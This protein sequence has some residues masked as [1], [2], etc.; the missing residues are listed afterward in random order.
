MMGNWRTC[1]S[2]V[3]S[4]IS[5]RAYTSGVRAVKGKGLIIP[6]GHLKKKI[7]GGA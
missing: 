1:N 6:R 3:K 7:G 4:D 5:S 2:E